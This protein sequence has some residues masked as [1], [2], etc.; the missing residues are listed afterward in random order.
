VGRHG[1]RVG[2][3]F[4][5][6]EKFGLRV[7]KEFC[8]PDITLHEGNLLLKM[9]AYNSKT[10]PLL[11]EALVPRLQAIGFTHFFT[12]HCRFDRRS[13]NII[14]DLKTMGEWFDQRM[15]RR[16]RG[17]RRK[18]PA[19][20]ALYFGILETQTRYGNVTNLNVIEV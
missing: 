19:N 7:F 18:T 9:L 6:G 13:P 2:L 12:G 8:C 14:G 20:T 11:K 5:V 3:Y 15:E 10:A 17:H 16:I 4:M 1:L